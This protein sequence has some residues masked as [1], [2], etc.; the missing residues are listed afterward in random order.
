MQRR[1]FIKAGG[2]L[3]ASS[4]FAR[5]RE[6]LAYSQEKPVPFP[7]YRGFN[8]TEKAGGRG[9]RRRFNEEDVAVLAEWGLNF[10]RIP[11]SYWNWS[12]PE[13]WNAFDESFFDDI[14]ALGIERA[15][16]Y[17]EAT[18]HVEEMVALVRKLMANGLEIGRA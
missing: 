17:P 18:K 16:H 3:V 9:P 4:I 7:R 11:M 14:D 8:L 15:E 13:D 5:E 12:R 2:A 6:T 10:A 1:E